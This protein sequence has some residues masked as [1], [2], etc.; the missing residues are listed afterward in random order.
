MKLSSDAINQLLRI[1]SEVDE[2]WWPQGPSEMLKERLESQ[3][4][5]KRDGKLYIK[6]KKEK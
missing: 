3:S 6:V 4:F 1:I 2:P 5:V